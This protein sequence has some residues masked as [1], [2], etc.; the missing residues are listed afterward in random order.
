[1]KNVDEGWKLM[2]VSDSFSHV[3]G[4][5]PVEFATLPLALS[6]PTRHVHVLISGFWI[7][8]MK[9]YL[10]TCKQISNKG[11]RKLYEAHKSGN[12]RLLRCSN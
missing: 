6:T 5:P 1:M 12:S 7:T 10:A 2:N 11:E 9:E 3:R 4:D 8:E